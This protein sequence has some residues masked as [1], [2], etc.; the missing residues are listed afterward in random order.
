MRGSYTNS[1]F[2][3]NHPSIN[4]TNFQGSET[5]TPESIEKLCPKKALQNKNLYDK[6]RKEF[7][8]FGRCILFL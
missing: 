4:N 6:Y 8:F 1:N 5:N 7:I 2:L 3:K